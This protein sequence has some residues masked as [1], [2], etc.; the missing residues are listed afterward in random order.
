[1]GD[2][3]FQFHVAQVWLK[4]PF[5]TEEILEKLRITPSLKGNTNIT[6]MRGKTKLHIRILSGN[7]N[8]ARQL[9]IYA[10]RPDKRLNITIQKVLPVLMPDDLATQGRAILEK[11][12]E[13]EE[14]ELWE[15]AKTELTQ[16]LFDLCRHPKFVREVDR[17]I[18]REIGSP[19]YHC[20]AAAGK[21]QDDHVGALSRTYSYDILRELT[22]A[23]A[24][25]GQDLRKEK[26]H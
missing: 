18:T 6:G 7:T 1:M 16:V 11:Q 26:G 19:A 12:R 2:D 13:E 22:E 21:D 17:R 24:S 4:K 8:S 15:K 20:W 10:D 3:K 5:T 25:G 14:S 9:D 23:M